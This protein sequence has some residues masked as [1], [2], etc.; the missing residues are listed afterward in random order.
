MLNIICYQGTANNEILL[1]PYYKG[2]NS[3]Y[4][5]KCW[6]GCGATGTFIH[7]WYKCKIVHIPWKRVW[8]F[9]TKLNILLPYDSAITLCGICPRE[10]KTGPQENQH[11]DIVGSLINN[12]QNFQA[13]KISISRLMDKK[14]VVYP[15]REHFSLLK[16]NELSSHEKTW[17]KLQWIFKA[18]RLFCKIL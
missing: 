14:T 1:Q 8:Q 4:N 18:V 5:T 2:K 12:C 13:T 10:L 3:K 11:I 16:R 7:F 6:Q 15:T 17:R 9:L